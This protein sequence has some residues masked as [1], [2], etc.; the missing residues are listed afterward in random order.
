MSKTHLTGIKPGSPA[1][2]RKRIGRL[3]RTQ[4]KEAEMPEVPEEVLEAARFVA[5][6]STVPEPEWSGEPHDLTRNP[7]PGLREPDDDDKTQGAAMN[8][9]LWERTLSGMEGSADE[10]FGALLEALNDLARKLDDS[11]LTRRPDS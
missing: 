2:D 9:D 7:P 1:P 10:W 5:G 8:A 4:A 6:Y 11:G 3:A